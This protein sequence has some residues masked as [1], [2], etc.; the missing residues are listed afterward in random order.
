MKTFKEYMN[1]TSEVGVNETS[2]T[3]YGMIRRLSPESSKAT[4][5]PNGNIVFAEYDGDSLRDGCVLLQDGS[6]YTFYYYNLNDTGVYKG[7][8]SKIIKDIDHSGYKEILDLV[9]NYNS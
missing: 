6:T 8:L 5:L 3:A 2:Q 9:K 4:R 1:E 7:N